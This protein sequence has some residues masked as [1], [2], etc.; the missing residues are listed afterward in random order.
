MRPNILAQTIQSKVWK[1]LLPATIAGKEGIETRGIIMANYNWRSS[2]R[3]RHSWDPVEGT[4]F[5]SQYKIP[6]T[7]CALANHHLIGQNY[8]WIQ[9]GSPSSVET[10]IKT[11]KTVYLKFPR[12]LQPYPFTRT[13]CW[14]SKN[15]I[16]NT[17]RCLLSY[18]A[19]KIW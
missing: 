17:N 11:A 12:H 13:K 18:L 4:C 14:H 9:A 10:Q 15:L 2:I 8:N 6:Q 5:R 1:N 3:Y 16:W 7:N 19:L